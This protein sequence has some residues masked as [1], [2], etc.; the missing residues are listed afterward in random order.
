MALSVVYFQFTNRLGR[1]ITFGT[2]ICIV[3]C[4]KLRF[5]LTVCVKWDDDDER[6]GRNGNPVPAHS[7]FFSKSTK[8]LGLT[9]ASDGR[10]AINSTIC[11]LNIHTAEGFGNLIQACDVQSSDWKV[12]I[13]TPPSPEMENFQMKIYYSA[14]D[15]TLYPL[16]QRQTCYHL[17]LH[18][19]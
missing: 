19:Y 13:S 7:L 16:N 6:K 12:Y 3:Y 15:W 1:H 4:R 18:V 10:N 2:S 11:I 8:G 14:G 17:S 5:R 9:S